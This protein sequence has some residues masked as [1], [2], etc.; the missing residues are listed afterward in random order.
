MP[1]SDSKL[2]F[3]DGYSVA[4]L[5]ANAPARVTCPG[6]PNHEP[7]W[8]EGMNIEQSLTISSFTRHASKIV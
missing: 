5:L 8:L 1:S 6:L 2:S 7:L 3:L 4:L